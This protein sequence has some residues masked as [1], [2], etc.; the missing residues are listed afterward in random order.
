MHTL[1][2]WHFHSLDR[3][4]FIKTDGARKCPLSGRYALL[5]RTSAEP[6]LGRAPQQTSTRQSKRHY[7]TKVVSEEDRWGLGCHL[8]Q[9]LHLRDDA[10]Y[11]FGCFIFNCMKASSAV[12]YLY[13]HS[14]DGGV[15]ARLFAVKWLIPAVCV[16]YRKM[17]QK[18]LQ[19]GNSLIK[20]FTCLY[21]TSIMRLK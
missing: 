5:I 4:K 1:Q 17:C 3:L 20:V 7:V 16:S 15:E 14:D 2:N 18:V 6:A 13:V 21:C 19:D 8:G 12:N 9:G 10:I 11:S